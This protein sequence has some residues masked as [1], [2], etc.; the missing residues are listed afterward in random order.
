MDTCG[1]ISFSSV[2]CIYCCLFYPVIRYVGLYSKAE[3]LY[4]DC[5][6]KMRVALGNNHPSALIS[7]NNLADLYE[8]QGN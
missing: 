5:L 8:S 3:P 4:V 7:M 2:L 1:R 6:Q